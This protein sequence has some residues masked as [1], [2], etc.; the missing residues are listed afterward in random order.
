MYII[1]TIVSQRITFRSATGILIITVL[2]VT[3]TLSGCV[4]GSPPGKNTVS[5]AP[6][7]SLSPT[8]ATLATPVVTANPVPTPEAPEAQVTLADNGYVVKGFAR[9]SSQIELREGKVSFHIKLPNYVVGDE[10]T[11]TV[12]SVDEPFSYVS[13]HSFSGDAGAGDVKISKAIPQDGMYQISLG[14]DDIWEIDVT[15]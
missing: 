2:L 1:T 15:Q 4:S 5:T 10:Y 6:T 11:L 7:A 9:E 14:Y 8:T 3:A 13:T 12:T